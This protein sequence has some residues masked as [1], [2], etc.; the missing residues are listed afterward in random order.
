MYQHIDRAQIK[1]KD[2]KTHIK[3]ILY[4]YIF[5]ILFFNTLIAFH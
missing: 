5:T 2:L 1:R 4:K 3:V